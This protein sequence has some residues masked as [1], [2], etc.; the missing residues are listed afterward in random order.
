MRC[1]SKYPEQLLEGNN[2]KC[3]FLAHTFPQ[4]ELEAFLPSVAQK[5]QAF[6]SRWAAL[7]Q[8]HLMNRFAS[9]DWNCSRILS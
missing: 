7:P 6:P 5:A 3:T 2:S 1:F 4:G 9:R 8:W